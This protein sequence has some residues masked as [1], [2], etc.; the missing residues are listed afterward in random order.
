M[1]WACGLGTGRLASH[2]DLV[3][4]NV[5]SLTVQFVRTNVQNPKISS[6]ALATFSIHQEL[7][8]SLFQDGG[9]A[10]DLTRELV[11]L[12]DEIFR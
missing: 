1:T 11:E 10:S 6:V 4:E 3:L 9:S 2:F 12:H 8:E 7:P 5:L